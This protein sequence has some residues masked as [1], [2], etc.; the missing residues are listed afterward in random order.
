MAPG[1]VEGEWVFPKARVLGRGGSWI[2]RRMELVFCW[3]VEG[4]VAWKRF[5]PS[6]APS[7]LA[8]KTNGLP[9]PPGFFF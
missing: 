4:K 3:Q 8:T 1:R 5:I 6:V 9:L 2:R 7:G